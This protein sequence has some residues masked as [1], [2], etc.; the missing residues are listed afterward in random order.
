MLR[1]ISRSDDIFG[2]A[3]FAIT[4]AGDVFFR[5]AGGGGNSCVVAEV[6]VE[7]Y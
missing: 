5:F 3:D 2:I 7:I 6:V 4:G 1:D